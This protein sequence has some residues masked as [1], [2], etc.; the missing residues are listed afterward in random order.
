MSFFKPNIDGRGRVARGLVSL[1]CAGAGVWQ[2]AADHRIAAW[3]L[4]GSALF[5]GFEA[6]RGWCVARACGI[7]TRI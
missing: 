5:T 4:A 3:I 1:V 2:Y 6:C 7:K